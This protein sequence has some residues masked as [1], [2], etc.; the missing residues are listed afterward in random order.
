MKFFPLSFKVCITLVILNFSSYAIALDLELTQGVKKAIP[1]TILPFTNDS[2]SGNADIVYDVI[3]NDLKNSGQFK[4]VDTGT[5]TNE[6]FDEKQDYSYWKHKGINNLIVGKI[7]SLTNNLFSVRFQLLDPVSQS[8]VLLSK[9]YQVKE[10]DL[11]AL[12]HH[13]SDLLYQKLIGERGIFSTRIAYVLVNR[14]DDKSTFK[15]EVADADGHSPQTLLVSSQPIMSPAW[16]PNGK[17]IAYVSFEN[18]RSQI[19]I[20]NVE[21]GQR[22]LISNYPGING[23]PAWSPDGKKL[24]IVLSKG[25]SPKLY[26]VNLLN[27]SIKQLTHGMSIDTEPSFSPD[28]KFLLFTSGRGGAPQIYRYNLENGNV[29]RVTF[30]GNYNARASMTSDSKKIIMQ[31]RDEKRFSIGVQD[32]DTGNLMPLTFSGIDESPSVSPNGRMILYATRYKNKGVLS[33]V[34]TDGK[35][36]IRLPSRDGDVQEPAWSPYLG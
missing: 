14:N 31:H 2:G 29:S 8:S 11:R 35:I 20:V 21:T 4:L 6:P 5:N 1:I 17:E 23:A 19:F 27:N 32:M 16:S 10:S 22:R 25:G 33:V 9:S 36:Q 13:I 24:A 12:A 34:S 26:L 28:G 7:V 3:R 30:A 15:L 18:K